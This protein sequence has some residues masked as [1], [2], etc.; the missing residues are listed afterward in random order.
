M[1]HVLIVEDDPCVRHVT[2][3]LLEDEGYTVYATAEEG[4]EALAILRKSPHPLVVITD[5]AHPGMLGD[6]FLQRVAQDPILSTRHVYIMC[7]ASYG[8]LPP[9]DALRQ[10]DGIYIPKPWD[11]ADFLEVVE[12]M[13]R[14]LEGQSRSASAAS[15][16]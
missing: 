9:S 16:I 7:S 8:G 15:P 3:E 2:R 13:A 4:A 6:E 14:R 12:R 10:L 11:F 1:T 5:H